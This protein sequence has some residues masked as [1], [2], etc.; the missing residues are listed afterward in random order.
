[1]RRRLLNTCFAVLLCALPLSAQT[2]DIPQ[3]AD[4]KATERTVWHEWLIG[5]IFLVGCLVVAFKPAKRANLR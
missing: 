4:T 5:S 1:M 2:Y 3:E